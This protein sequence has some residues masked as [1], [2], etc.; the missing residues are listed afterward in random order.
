MVAPASA[1]TSPTRHARMP[2][3]W[4]SSMARSACGSRKYGDEADA[5]VQGALQIGL[6]HPA[7][8]LDRLEDR[9]RRP[10]RAVEAGQQARGENPGQVRCEPTSGDV[11]QGVDLD[12][13][14]LNE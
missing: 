3:S 4:L 11:A 6:R 7:E 1:V 8:D 10:G 9:R 5:L 2:L 12:A 14:V 13:S